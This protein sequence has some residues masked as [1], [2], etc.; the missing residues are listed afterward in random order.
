MVCLKNN[1]FSDPGILYG[2]DEHP[3]NIVAHVVIFVLT[4]R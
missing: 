1:F 3:H 4:D 2:N